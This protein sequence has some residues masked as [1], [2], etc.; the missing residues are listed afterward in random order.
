MFLEVKNLSKK[1]QDKYA[2]KDINFSLDE[3]KLM[4]FLGPSGCGKSTI[5]KVIGGFIE[6]SGE[7]YLDGKLIN[8]LPPEERE[9]ST[10]FQSF[11]LF[12]HMNVLENI[13]YG[14]KFREKNKA[15]IKEKGL[16]MLDKMGLSGYQN[17][18]INELS[19]GE[20]QRVALGRSLIIEPKLLLLDEPLSSLDA[21]LQEEMRGEIKRFQHEFNIT[22]I[23]VTHNQKEAFEISDEIML[24]NNGE[25]MQIGTARELYEKPNNRFVLEFIGK[26]NILDNSYIRPEDIAITNEGEDAKIIDIIYQGELSIL[27]LKY[28][29]KTIETFVIN[30]ESN[31]SIGDNIKIIIRKRQVI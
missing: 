22:T 13:V 10:V 8:N 16:K 1:Y 17:R 6:S 31:Y 3:G 2:I 28:Q 24:L 9:I 30:N 29:G 21:K 18:Y 14:L 20:K 12:P 11:G 19:G 23:F 27:K 7:I 4:C 25:I 15:I 5:L 26:S